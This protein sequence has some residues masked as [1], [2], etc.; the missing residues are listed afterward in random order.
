MSDDIKFSNKEK[1]DELW[2][3]GIL[4]PWK[5]HAVQKQI[6]QAFKESDKQLFVLNCSRRLGKSYFLC[7]LALEYAL[8]HPGAQIKF[9]APNQKMVRKIIAPLMKQILGNCP[10]QLRPRFKGLDGVYEFPNGSEISVAGT[11]M[12]QIDN[13]RGQACDLALIDEA[14]FATDLEYVLNSVLI[15]Q[16]LTRPN[17]RIILASTPPITPDHAFVGYAQRA[18]SSN[19]YAKFT[20]YDNPMLSHEL[21]E[22]YKE[23]AG[24]DKSTSWRREYLAEFVTDRD[25]A[26]FPEA[27]EDL[28][29]EIT[30]EVERPRF[31]HPIVVADLG[32]LD[33]TG[34]LFAYWDFLNARIVIE[35][36]ILIN[37]TTSGEIVRQIK[38]KEK[39]LWGDVEVKTR[40]VDGN[41]LAIADL[42][43]MH[44][45]TCRAPEKSDLT[46]NINRVRIDLQ[47]RRL[48]INPRC[49]NLLNQI[50][51]STWDNSRTKFSRSSSGGHWDLAASLVYLCKSIDRKT[52]PIPADFGWDYYNDWGFPRRQQNTV[53]S[54]FR[55]LFPTLHNRNR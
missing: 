55:R 1:V 3:R 54:K 48:A 13:L 50:Q 53:A 12:G 35:D 28:L 14:G 21:I 9:A 45:F 29:A 41:A 47:D 10:K 36:E 27:S 19:S 7:V 46:A 49:K 17:A 42:N 23:E 16:T 43:A 34:I 32:Y 15:P 31:F 33:F 40:I 26:L 11:E 4:A 30:Q 24:G 20:I 37:K 39:E 18:M 51:F 25:S 8:Q 2:R 52:N 6:Y 5:L 44:K 38:A 22:R